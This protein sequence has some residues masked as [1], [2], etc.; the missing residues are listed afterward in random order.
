MFTDREHEILDEHFGEW[1][2][3]TYGQPGFAPDRVE[4][5]ENLIGRI[6]ETDDEPTL[7]AEFEAILDK[8]EGR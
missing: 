4:I 7:Q 5:I 1:F 3:D 2:P 6:R 8:Y